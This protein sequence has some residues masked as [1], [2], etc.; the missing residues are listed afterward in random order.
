MSASDIRAGKA[1]VALGIKDQLTK[2]LKGIGKQVEAFGRGVEAVGK[3][4]AMLGGAVTAPMLAATAS[5]AASG[6]ELYR[7]S[8]RT[9]M[10]AEALSALNF[11]AEESGGSAEGMTAAV[12]KMNEALA[13]G[14]RGSGEMINAF[15]Q[16][17]LSV[18]QLKSMS[19][20]QQFATMA[21]KISQIKD[22]AQQ[23]AFAMKLFGRGAMDLMPL[24]K[25]GAAGLESY[26]HQA[27]EMGLI[28][29]S[30]TVKAAFDLDMAWKR[31]GGSL[32]TIKGAVASTLAPM[33]QRI[34]QWTTVIAAKVRDWVRANQPLI[35]T[36]FKVGAT[37]LGVGSA[38]AIVGKG[39]SIVG[40]MF[41]TAATFVGLFSQVLGVVFSALGLLTSPV[42][43]L[44]T[45]IAGLGV[46]FLYST[47]VM[48]KAID[49]LG[50]TF[51]T[52]LKDAKDAFGAIADAIQA[53]DL[54]PPSRSPR[55]SCASNGRSSRFGCA[56]S[57]NPSRVGSSRAIL[58]WPSR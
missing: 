47:G 19:P 20:E 56:R 21:N 44:G 6:A 25:Q 49:W 43:I 45:A 5:W 1:F 15:G 36:S 35:V 11:A 52:L 7:L 40:G 38:L 57:G 23:T 41:G 39:I 28:K 48:Q 33:L 27:E 13:E 14:E 42:A 55:P 8:Q 4:F 18:Q 9:G 29:N 22:P 17:G 26:R 31:A 50:G 10:S 12:R 32:N 46:Y 53:G 24:L 3:K 2:S 54:R 37:L 16:L 51:G 34:A 58:P 30:E